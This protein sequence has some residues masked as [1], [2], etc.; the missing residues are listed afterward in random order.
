M[1]L[2]Y[3]AK[4]FPRVSETFIANE[5]AELGRH[6]IDVHVISLLPSTVTK[7]WPEV[8]EL[9]AKTTVLPDPSAARARTLRLQ[10]RLFR[11]RPRPYARAFLQVLLRGS[12][13]TWKRFFQ[14]GFLLDHCDALGLSHV[15]AAF[16]HTPASVAFWVRRLGGPDYS[17][18]AHAKDLYLSEPA[19]LRNK[20][21][22]A[23]FVWTCT[24]A[25]G[26]YLRS[27]S[28]ATPI[29]VGYH[30]VDL[31]R[32]GGEATTPD[33][34][35]FRVL[36]LCRLVPKKGLPHLLEAAAELRRRGV[37]D[38]EVV[39]GGD[40]PERARLEAQAQQLGLD[41]VVRFVGT[42]LSEDVRSAYRAADLFV[43]PSVILENGDRDGI[44]NVLVEA[45]AMGV[46][47]VSTRVSGIPELVEDG[48]SGRLVAPADSG[49]LADAV[50]EL[51]R[52]A[53]L[54]AALA[55]GGRA[56]VRERFDLHQNSGRLADRL[57]R[58]GALR[59][60]LYVSQDLGIPIR[61]HKGASAHVRQIA[62]QFAARGLAVSVLSPDPGPEPPDGNAFALPVQVVAPPAWT[63]RWMQHLPKGTARRDVAKETRR[64]LHNAAVFAAI[65]REPRPDFVYE[66]YALTAVATGVSCRLRRIPWILEVNAPLADEE[67]RFRGLRWGRLTRALERWCLGHAD[68]VFVV[69]HALRRWALE[70]GVHPDRVI[71]LPNGVDRERFRPGSVEVGDPARA[72]IAVP[73]PGTLSSKRL[74]LGFAPDD[75]VVAFSGSLKPWH[76]GEVLLDA[77]AEARGA[78]PA[79]RLLFVGDGPEKKNLEKRA[80]KKGLADVVVF[81]GAVPHDQVPELLLASD[82]LVAPYL[83][84]DDFYFSPLKVLEYLASGRPV[85][86]S[87]IGEI[88]ELVDASCGRLVAPGSVKELARVLAD[89]GLDPA[90]RAELGRRARERTR[91]AD[92]SDRAATILEAAA[93]V[94]ATGALPR[95]ER[96]GYVLK[97]FPRFSET[98]VLREV[99]ELERQGME[100]RTFSM[101]TPHGPQQ[102]DVARVHAL[103]S[104]L[105]DPHRL[106]TPAVLGAHA[107][108][109]LRGPSRYFGAL[110]FAITRRDR[111][112]LDKFVQA[113]VVADACARENIGHLHAHFASG[114]TRVV[115]LASLI[116]GVPFSFTAHAKD[117]YWHGHRHGTSKKLKK[118]VQ[119]A[120]F[121]A[122]ISE[123]NRRFIE[124]QGFKVK[125]GRI[126]PLYIGLRMDD[127]RFTLPSARPRSP[128]PLV[129]AVGRL[130]EKKGFHVLLE[131]TAELV[132][133]GVRLRVAI[134]GEGPEESALRARIQDL[135]LEGTVRLLGS[136]PLE[137][138]RRRYYAR[139]R[140]LVQPCVVAKDGDQDGIPT[141]LL[142]AMAL[143]VPVISTKVSGIPEAITDGE[144]GYLTEPGDVSLLATR[145]AALLADPLLADRLALR[146]RARAECQFDLERNVG[147]LRKLFRRSM[148]G[149]PSR[150]A[151]VRLQES[152][153][154]VENSGTPGY[155]SEEPA[156]AG[157]EGRPAA[158]G[159]SAPEIPAPSTVEVA[160]AVGGWSTAT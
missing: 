125:E 143:G 99:L 132:Q 147:A 72:A 17:F 35:T 118:R 90:L 97:M 115:K 141:V 81:T 88:G 4:M 137:R 96:V 13:R 84:H 58:P 159:P 83:P 67:A 46:P 154:E 39:V 50:A 126:R 87:A 3:V 139:A 138:L 34:R 85:V 9:A 49:A 25:N 134:A 21:E 152:W 128:R 68:A 70:R 16:A 140:V 43:L 151:W 142:E 7:L 157:Y 130:I 89:L 40:G 112:A 121:V 111:K 119:L 24:E 120:R 158:P 108:C 2:A 136:V 82:L 78:V 48:V 59:R 100:V 56:A 79:L 14:A 80:R 106:L 53:E 103:Q 10:G 5:I 110:R 22:E 69:S 18:T 31:T 11:R 133:R 30:G 149:W 146:A 63:T 153:G 20:M 129:L 127:Y 29:E 15:H 41:G 36:T 66:R 73:L 114:P 124:S 62:G 76:G 37:G 12:T 131:A 54:R 104:V 107:R 45:M 113:G 75:V 117:L 19:S 160:A 8:A 74:R 26:V 116:S 71:T 92:W 102:A 51:M 65:L 42:L 105:P 77:F 32:F 101:K 60:V 57:R 6:G 135:G 33:R 86:A 94:A 155:V 91:G 64:L 145:I 93:A 156:I 98:F 95:R 1:R 52:S 47:V 61:G 55:E 38:F 122:V 44:P 23:R 123:E 28:T 109:L 150:D 148:A 27:I 144:D